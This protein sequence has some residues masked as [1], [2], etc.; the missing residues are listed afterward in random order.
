MLQSLLNVQSLTPADG[1]VLVVG[2]IWIDDPPLV[3]ADAAHP[4]YLQHNSAAGLALGLAGS[5]LPTTLVG[6][7]GDD[8]LADFTETA[9]ADAGVASDLLHIKAWST[10]TS[11]HL[12]IGDVRDAKLDAQGRRV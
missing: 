1:H 5:R 2:D 11:A 9:L 6:F 3:N 10:F 12:E 8:A 7:V 4:E